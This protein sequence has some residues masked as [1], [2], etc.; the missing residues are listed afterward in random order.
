MKK[1]KKLLSLLLAGV[2]LTAMVG[3]ANDDNKDRH[4]DGTNGEASTYSSAG[5]EFS[6]EKF[7]GEW[8]Y[9]VNAENCVFQNLLIPA[10]VNQDTIHTVYKVENALKI[11]KIKMDDGIT[12]I[13]S[14]AFSNCL[15][16][17]SI[18]IPA[19]VTAV[20]TEIFFDCPNLT[21]IYCAAESQPEGWSP[22]WL[23]GCSATV[24]WGYK[25]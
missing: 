18:Y 22:D 23:K 16:L 7:R 12:K 4:D 5:A 1:A 10:K 6:P 20:G 2:M 13:I 9:V 8:R 25:G 14:H 21:D 15:S 24:H 19:S 11:K 3:C 17:E